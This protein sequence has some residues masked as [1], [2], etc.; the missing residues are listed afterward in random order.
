MIGHRRSE[1]VEIVEN[2]WRYDR[3]KELKQ[4]LFYHTPII[5]NMGEKENHERVYNS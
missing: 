2:Q 3:I 5:I 1:E 4:Q